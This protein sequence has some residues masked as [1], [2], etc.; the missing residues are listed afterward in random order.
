M[1]KQESPNRGTGQCS[2][3][4]SSST[5]KA[6]WL[7]AKLGSKSVSQTP[8]TANSAGKV[9]SLPGAE[10]SITTTDNDGR[11]LSFSHA[12]IG[13]PWRKAEAVRGQAQEANP[14]EK[15]HSTLVLTTTSQQLQEGWFHAI[16]KAVHDLSSS[17]FV[18]PGN[19]YVF[20]PAQSNSP[21]DRASL[22]TSVPPETYLRSSLPLKQKLELP[23]FSIHAPSTSFLEIGDDEHRLSGTYTPS[24]AG[25]AYQTSSLTA[26][27]EAD[28]REET[29]ELAF[30]FRTEM[31]RGEQGS[32]S[33]TA[34]HA[35]GIDEK[36]SWS[37]EG[38]RSSAP[39]WNPLLPQW[40]D[41]LRVSGSAERDDPGRTGIRTSR[42]SSELCTSA[43]TIGALAPVKQSLA[44]E[45]SVPARGIKIS[46][47]ASDCS[48]RFSVPE[49]ARR[50]ANAPYVSHASMMTSSSSS[51]S[52]AHHQHQKQAAIHGPRHP[53]LKTSL[54][55]SSLSTASSPR[56]LVDSSTVSGSGCH[57][58]FDDLEPEGDEEEE[59]PRTPMPG[60]SYAINPNRPISP[61]IYSLDASYDL[62]D[63]MLSP[64]TAGAAGGGTLSA[65]SARKLANFFGSSI[66]SPDQL[67]A[68]PASL[69]VT[70]ARI[71]GPASSKNGRLHSRAMS[72]FSGTKAVTVAT[73]G[74]MKRAVG[75]T[76]SLAS[77]P[78]PATSTT[79]PTSS[80]MTHTLSGSSASSEGESS[81]SSISRESG[82]SST[83]ASTGTS[84]SD[85]PLTPPAPASILSASSK[86]LTPPARA[87]AQSDVGKHIMEPAELRRKMEER[88]AQRRDRRRPIPL[89]SQQQHHRQ[90][91]VASSS[92]GS[93]SALANA[94][95]KGRPD[96]GGSFGDFS[97]MGTTTAAM[98]GRRPG[99][100][101]PLSEPAK[102]LHGSGRI[103][104]P[105]KQPQSSRTL[106]EHQ[107]TGMTSPISSNSSGR[108]ADKLSPISL[109]ISNGS[110]RSSPLASPVNN[111][112]P[113]SASKVDVQALLAA[114]PPPRRRA[115]TPTPQ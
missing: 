28:E 7:K 65:A 29:E 20:P 22:D 105:I 40:L 84:S 10:A 70:N 110:R 83:S 47:H 78:L 79:A 62:Q 15:S 98:T 51:P 80:S 59:E 1:K 92:L 64:T 42:R 94:G 103:V 54:S 34:V 95:R 23:R 4:S 17:A 87:A 57:S 16:Q 33:T 18:V 97:P 88:L 21:A 35:A 85:Y 36:P 19:D 39:I 68:S 76:L 55:F 41:Q 109:S 104:D 11:R 56:N 69:D 13:L 111:T 38:R 100:A 49:E 74:R 24:I 86:D 14:A 96:L 37:R 12:A 113:S 81:R 6:Q 9:P 45:Q 91:M 60:S 77:A 8:L 90:G 44:V 71:P 46:L 32:V 99:T 63:P 73:G 50:A 106:Y 25:G 89:S 30:P 61:I 82:S 2:S 108:S 5:T 114:L 72:V 115:A 66:T 58:N 3:S 93:L 31:T 52:I 101:P 48:A 75:H 53:G 107:P 26:E 67:P 43:S 27:G 112:I 102:S